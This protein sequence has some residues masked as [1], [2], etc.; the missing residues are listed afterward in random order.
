MVDRLNQKINTSFNKEQDRALVTGMYGFN[1]TSGKWNYANVD[2]NGDLKV[3]IHATGGG[4]D[5]KARTDIAD[6][7]TSTFL[8]CNTDGTLELTAELDSS[9]LAKSAIQTDGTQ[10]TQILGNTE[11]DGS[12]TSKHIHTDA[13][14]NVLTSIVSTVNVAPADTLNSGIT[15]DPANS[16]AVGLR[17]RT[18]ITDASTETFLLCDSQGHLQMDTAGTITI[19]GDTQVKAE[20]DTASA[21]NIRCNNS[22]HVKSQLIGN[23]V[24]DGSGTNKVVQV[25]DAG[26]LKTKLIAEDNTATRRE[27]RCNTTGHLQTALLGNTAGDGSGTI[28]NVVTDTDGHLQVDVLSGGGGGTQF[29]S[30]ATLGGTPTGTLLIGSNSGTAKE[31]AVNASGEAKV[32]ADITNTTLAITASALPLPTGGATSALQTSGNTSLASIDAKV[33]ACNTGAVTIS[34]SALPSG[35][36]SEATLLLAESHLGNIDT[37]TSSIQSN[38]ATSSNQTTANTSLASIDAKLTN[39]NQISGASHEQNS[40]SIATASGVVSTFGKSGSQAY[41][42]TAGFSKMTM[43]VVTTDTTTTPN[44]IV[45]W[46]D[47]TTFPAGS[48]IL[49]SGIFSGVLNVTSPNGLSFTTVSDIDSSNYGKQSA[50]FFDLFPARYARLQLEQFSGGAITYQLKSYLT[51]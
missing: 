12:G 41:I 2:D 17:G 50:V 29:A 37:A 34:S 20:D 23:T 19:T 25:N 42:D 48:I 15:N 43:V 28:K 11:G 32:S 35:A 3:N 38:V 47:D 1:A 5:L 10:K 8:K 39:G 7:A 22:G 4:G 33:T 40:H 46:S 49:G 9:A 24:G 18:N 51:A 26:Q 45:E 21:R 13:T 14:G 36:S 44:A 27:V 31:L 6:P 16:L 30:G